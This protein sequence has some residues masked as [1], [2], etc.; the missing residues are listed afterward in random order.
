MC[1]CVCV[2]VCVCVCVCMYVCVCV[3]VCTQAKDNNRIFFMPN[4]YSVQ[5]LLVKDAVSVQ[6]HNSTIQ[7]FV[8]LIVGHLIL[9]AAYS[10]Y[11][12]CIWIYTPLRGYCILSLFVMLTCTLRIDTA[13]K[14]PYFARMGEW[15]KDRGS[16]P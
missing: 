10:W 4:S 16:L 1:V 14:I 7:P 6:R 13:M 5:T 2:R 8:S 11:S 12:F 15:H 9:I 3:C